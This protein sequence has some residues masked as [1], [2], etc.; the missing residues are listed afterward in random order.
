M[1]RIRARYSSAAGE[2]WARSAGHTPA[3]RMIFGR[4]LVTGL[5]V[6]V[7][8][9]FGDTTRAFDTKWIST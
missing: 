7:L 5:L 1:R 6:A 3:E 8:L 4:L 9:A 2:L